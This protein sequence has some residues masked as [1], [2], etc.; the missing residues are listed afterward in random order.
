M[1]GDGPTRVR[2][3]SPGRGVV[4]D[5]RQHGRKG[6]DG[7]IGSEPRGEIMRVAEK[8][9]PEGRELVVEGGQNGEWI[10]K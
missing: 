7:G 9:I 2:G 1:Q 3:I 5:F 6:A 10:A 4:R 8:W